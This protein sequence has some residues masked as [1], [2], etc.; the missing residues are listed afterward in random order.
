MDSRDVGRALDESL[1]LLSPLVTRDWSAPAGELTWTCRQTAEHLAH[2]L[3][4]YA[5]Q[6]AARAD[7]RYLPLDLVVRPGTDARTVLRITAAC[8][9]LLRLELDAAGP[10]ARAWHW[11]P[12]DPT[13]FA[14]LAV[15]EILVHTWD[16]AQGLG[17]SW[18]PPANLASAVLRRLFPAVPH[19]ADPHAGRTLLWATGRIA[20]PNHPRRDSWVVKATR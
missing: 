10:E 13:G 4:A 5:T 17:S 8:A 14:A 20:L 12:T 16:I 11:G 6:L 1:T 2:D 18:T 19:D 15:N 7:E 9:R 3:T